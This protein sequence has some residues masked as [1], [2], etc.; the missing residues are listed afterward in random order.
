VRSLALILV[1]FTFGCGHGA[2]QRSTRPTTNVVLISIDCLNE[3]QLEEALAAGS[4]PTLEKIADDSLVFR[5]TYAQAPWTTPSH[6]SMFTGLYPSQHGRDIPWSLMIALTNEYDRV[7]T[8]RTIA[9]VLKDNG[10]ETQAVTGKG[11]ISA[12]FGTARGFD[13]FI[14][15]PK[16]HGDTDLPRSV[17]TTLTWLAH[18]H[19]GPF[20][21]FFHTYDFHIPRPAEYPSDEADL[22]YIDSQ[23]HR[24]VSWLEQNDLYDSALLILTGDH[25]S[26]MIHI[27]GKCCMHAAGHY[28]EN[29]KVPLLLKLPHSSKTGVSDRLVRHIDLYPTI[30]DVLGMDASL[31]DGPG[32]S[33]LD[34][35]APATDQHSPRYSF[36]EADGNCVVRYGL[37]SDRYNYIY[38]PRGLTQSTLRNDPRF[39][40]MMCR[41]ECAELPP[42]EELFDLADDPFEEHNLLDGAMDDALVA[43]LGEFREAMQAHLDLAPRYRRTLVTDKR[44]PQ[45]GVDEELQKSLKALGYLE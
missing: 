36:S 20:F 35:V 17:K 43:T 18:R 22:A 38:T 5:R 27:A 34:V 26:H 23:L 19:E 42:R 30:L 40:L 8:Y 9:E 14:E 39:E 41:G 45:A 11:A 29:L 28:Q 16:L 3:R 31:Y 13:S 24:L 10:Y 6:M 15:T 33:I 4:V 32:K 37:V 7:P 44:L 21:L 1:L 2:V 25:G 12:V